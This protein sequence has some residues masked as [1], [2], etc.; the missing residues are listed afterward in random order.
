MTNTSAQ[1]QI[2]SLQRAAR[3]SLSVKLLFCTPILILASLWLA[4][5]ST[6]AKPADARKRGGQAIPVTVA[7]AT[8][9]DMPVYLNG[10][11]SVTAF[12]TVSIKSRIDGQLTEVAF[13]EGQHVNKGDLLA[14]IDPRPYE[15]AVSQAQAALF[16]DQAQLKDA[17]LNYER[18][19]DL[20]QN[21]GAVSQQQVDTQQAT[22]HQFEGTIRTDQAAIDNAKL[23]LSYCHITAPES[24][25]I[26]LRLVDAG[27][28]VHANDTQP[29]L[30]I[31]KLQ[32]I[33]V[34]FTLPEDS[35]PSVAQH[36]RKGTLKVDAYSRDDQT[37]VASGT[38]LTI[39][40]QI[41]QTTGTGKLKAVFPNHDNSLWPNQ[42]VN[43]HLLLEVRKNTLVVPA[44]AVQRGQQGT[45]VFTVKPDKKVEVRQVTV[46]LTQNNQAVIAS[47]LQPNEIVVTDGQDKLDAQSLV[48]PH[49]S[50]PTGSHSQSSAG[51]A[52]Q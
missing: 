32:P 25:R 26:G 10:L 42:F 50:G 37:K 12:N 2:A 8:V 33:A 34:L 49:S 15:V 28:M 1:L 51:V 41:D 45:Y 36:M 14:I 5:S 22:V 4:C 23:Q 6:D 9:E 11:G 19:K 18:F 17:K 48:E 35:L 52:G 27:N 38:L 31:T 24:G 13:K 3:T 7:T 29:L 46:A 39:D 16:R 44:A 43:I 40:N 47:G 20:L 21:S 30:V